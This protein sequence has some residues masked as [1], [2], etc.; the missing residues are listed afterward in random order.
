[1]FANKINR[2]ITGFVLTAAILTSA[3]F[4]PTAAKKVSAFCDAVTTTMNNTVSAYE[5]VETQYHK[6]QEDLLDETYSAEKGNIEKFQFKRF[7]SD[8]SWQARKLVIDGLNLYAQNLKALASNDKLTEFD[9][10]TTALGQELTKLQGDAV[11]AKILTSNTFTA[12]EISGFTTAIHTIGSW[13]IDYT[14]QKAIKGA[15]KDLQIAVR[16]ICVLFAKEIGSSPVLPGTTDL[17][18]AQGTTLRKILWRDYADLLKKKNNLLALNEEALNDAI[19][20]KNLAYQSLLKSQR[21]QLLADLLQVKSD[22]EQADKT[23]DA[24]AKSLEDIPLA[25]DN[26]EKAFDDKDTTLIAQIS[27]IFVEAENIKNYYESLGK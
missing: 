13:Y 26:I 7:I 19:A 20:K 15:G 17:D 25:H 8:D 5:M 22:R 23:L 14:R 9:G 10:K 21:T 3:C 6:R 27:Q 24:V 1:M 18:P 16:N 11:K 2:I 12:N 4:P